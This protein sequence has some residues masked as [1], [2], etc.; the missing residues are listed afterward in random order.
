ML[1]QPMLLLTEPSLQNP[2]TP[3]LKSSFLQKV[4]HILGW[5]KLAL[6][7]GQ[8][9]SSACALICHVSEDG[10]DSF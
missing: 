1:I 5:F 6:C 10:V 8:I 7:M 9:L 4:S 2:G 3:M